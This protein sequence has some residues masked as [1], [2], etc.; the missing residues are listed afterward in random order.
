MGHVC[1]VLVFICFQV[2][3]DLFW[4]HCEPIH[5]FVTCSLVSMSLCVFKFISLWL[6]PGF[7]PLW[8]EKMCDMSSIFLNVL[9]LVL[10]PTMWVNLENVP[11]ALEENVSS[12]AL[13]WNALQISIKSTWSSVAF[14]AA[15]SLWIFCLEDPSID[16]NRVL[17]SPTMTVLPSVSPFMSSR[18]CST[19]RCSYVGCTCLQELHPLVGL[20]P[21]SLCSVLLC[22]LLQRQFLLIRDIFFLSL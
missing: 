9:R 8:P 14:K 7:T 5:C 17:K 4:S 13:E 12:A 18:I 6:I 21:L 16:V 19:F 3:F 20:L 11:C 15:V 22:L 2:P 1:C 10:C